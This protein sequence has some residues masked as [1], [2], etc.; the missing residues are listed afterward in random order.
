MSR[1]RARWQPPEA[2]Q[3]QPHPAHSAPAGRLTLD[4]EERALRL[5]PGRDCD[6]STSRDARP[7][8]PVTKGAT[9]ASRL[10]LRTLTLAPGPQ[11]VRGPSWPTRGP[12]G[13][14][15]SQHQPPGFR[16]HARSLVAPSGLSSTAYKRG[17][18]GN[19]GAATGTETHG[20]RWKSP[21]SP[22]TFKRQLAARF[23]VVKG[24]ASRTWLRVP[25]PRPAANVQLQGPRRGEGQRPGPAPST[26]ARVLTAC[27][28]G[29]AA[30]ST[31]ASRGEPP[32]RPAG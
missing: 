30:P 11:A 28:G 13:E 1:Q 6:R 24:L 20:R 2:R 29:R 23:V 7:V 3:Q 25:T 4:S 9:A 18:V 19:R 21:S 16:T 26:C 10:S 14:A 31:L 12:R 17:A 5:E 22:F 27:G 32:S 15:S 8:R